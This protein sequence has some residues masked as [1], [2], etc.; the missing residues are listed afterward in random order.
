MLE[1]LD[2]VFSIIAGWIDQTVVLP[3]L[4]H[5]GW[6]QWEELSFDWMLICVYGVFTLIVTYAVCWPLEALFPVEHWPSKKAV[7][8]DMFYTVLQRV[9]VLPIFSFLVF[10]QVQVWVNG[11]V[12]MHGYIPPM[13]ETLFPPLFGHPVL[14]FIAY[15]LILDCSDYWRHRLSHS[16]RSWYA[17]HALHHAQ[18]Q[19]SF[20]S[21]DR[22]HLLD[23][24]IAG[25]WFGVVGLAI[26]IPP[27]QFPLLMMF[28][29]FVESLSHANVRL[30]FGWLGERLLV[31]PRFH[32]VHH[33]LRAAGR[34]SCNYGAVFPIWDIIFGTADFADEY[35]A[36]GDRNA[37]EPMVSGGYFA[38]QTS[39]LL[40]FWKQLR[41][42]RMK[43]AQAA[44]SNT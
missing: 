32:R 20:W 10:Y 40:Y 24:L 5:L 37:P 3:I 26:G 36:T 16:F 13:L 25:V 6:M 15:A 7:V 8:T 12:V 42:G 4:Y 33:G 9:G 14:T 31:S 21:D 35:P 28:M 29:R 18:K 11:F 39:G 22:N 44:I 34:V 17:L 41:R 1:S 2:R 23:D 43:K 19:M 38:Q 27:L 30:S